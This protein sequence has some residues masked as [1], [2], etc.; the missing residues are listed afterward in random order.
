MNRS[1][2]S[3]V[4]SRRDLGCSVHVRSDPGGIPI[5]GTFYPI[6]S[7]LEVGLPSVNLYVPEFVTPITSA[8]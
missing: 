6:G 8:S 4:V 7:V 5:S 2:P 3:P 1:S